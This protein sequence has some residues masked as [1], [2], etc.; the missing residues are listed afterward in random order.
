MKALFLIALLLFQQPEPVLRKR[1]VM[2]MGSRFD[3]TIV[4]GDSISAEHKIDT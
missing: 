2:L 3:I 4:A 1:T